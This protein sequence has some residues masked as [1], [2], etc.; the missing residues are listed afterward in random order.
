MERFKKSEVQA[1]ASVS[2]LPTKLHLYVTVT[3]QS[4]AAFLNVTFVR[5]FYSS[6]MQVNL[7]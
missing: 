2:K 5:N 7:F 1:E 4:I 3:T 6:S